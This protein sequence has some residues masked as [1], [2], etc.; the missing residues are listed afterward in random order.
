MAHCGRVISRDFFFLFS[1]SN[2]T[3]VILWEQDTRTLSQFQ[4]FVL[5]SAGLVEQVDSPFS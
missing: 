5:V 2:L 1:F 4:S 3:S